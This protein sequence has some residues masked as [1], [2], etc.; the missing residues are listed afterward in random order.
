M[1]RPLCVSASSQTVQVPKRE[2][3]E[4]LC[5]GGAGTETI[6]SHLVCERKVDTDTGHRNILGIKNVVLGNMKY[7]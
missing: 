1:K 3:S 7:E 5:A 4:P 2:A 6:E